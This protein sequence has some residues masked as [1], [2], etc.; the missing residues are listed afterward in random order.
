MESQNPIIVLNEIN[1]SP[2]EIWRALS[3]KELMIQWFFEG[4]PSFKAE[5]GFRT[6]FVVSPGERSFTHQWEIL[7]VIPGKSITYDWSYKEYPGQ[8]KVIFEIE[9]Q[10]ASSK[11]T[12]KNYGLETFPSEIPEFSRE[13]CTGGWQYFLSRLKEFLETTQ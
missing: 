13:N 4:I 8:G 3:E 5:V 2:E 9:D 1:A 6:E 7:E 10:G 12:V 11:V